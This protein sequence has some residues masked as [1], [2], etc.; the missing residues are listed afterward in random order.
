MTTTTLRCVDGFVVTGTIVN[1]DDEFVTIVVDSTVG[2]IIPT[3][4]LVRP[5]WGMVG[6]PMNSCWG[7]T[8]HEFTEKGVSSCDHGCKVYRCDYCHVDQVI[9]SLSYGCQRLTVQGE[10]S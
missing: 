8:A 2:Y 5:N 3:E 1:A 9:H 10:R 7:H 4:D 6:D